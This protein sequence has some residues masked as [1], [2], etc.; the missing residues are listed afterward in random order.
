VTVAILPATDQVVEFEVHGVPRPQ[1]SKRFVGHAKSGRAIL[2]ESSDRGVRDWRVSVIDAARQALA[3]RERLTG[4]VVL[5]VTFYF[6]RPK[7][8]YGKRGLLPS[9]PPRHT[10]KPDAS[11]ILRSLEDAITDAGVWRDD[12][13][14]DDDHARKEWAEWSGARV[15]ITEA[16]A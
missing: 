8:H 1:G 7:S 13:Q 3:G 10:Q 2:I 12:S 6:A 15:R 4:A 9:A 14:V 11:K 16:S 5:E